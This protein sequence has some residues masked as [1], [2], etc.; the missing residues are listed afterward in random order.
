MKKIYHK[1]KNI[2]YKYI[3]LFINNLN[4]SNREKVVWKTHSSKIYK[5]N[6]SL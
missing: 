4:I 1:Y 3:Y 5:I 6:D 2:H